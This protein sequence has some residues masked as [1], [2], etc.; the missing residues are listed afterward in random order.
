[1]PMAG[2]HV[3]NLLT[4]TEHVLASV[5]LPPVDE[6]P[7]AAKTFR[8]DRV[9]GRPAPK[10]AAVADAV[11]NTMVALR[12]E[13]GQVNLHPDELVKLRSGSIVPLHQL[14]DDLVDVYANGRLVARGEVVVLDGNFGVRVVEL[15]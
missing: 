7:S 9:H 4:E 8:R 2:E 13:L 1:M 10:P 14:A 15:T 3:M 6:L 12:I 11:R 5:A